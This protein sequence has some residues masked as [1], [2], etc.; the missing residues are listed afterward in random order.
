[1]SK[2][3]TSS[4]CEVAGRRG[5]MP[6]LYVVMARRDER[7]E[8]VETWAGIGWVQEKQDRRGLFVECTDSTESGVREAIEAT[9]TSMMKSRGRDYGPI[10]WE[11]A[12]APCHG[13]PSCALVI[14]VYKS[15]GWDT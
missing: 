6:G 11:I 9:L 15:Q 7:T 13:T 3:T 5:T 12:G 2:A 4:R 8:G 14:A 10:Q 1:M